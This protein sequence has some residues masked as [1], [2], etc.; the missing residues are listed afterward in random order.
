MRCCTIYNIRSVFDRTCPQPKREGT[1][2]FGIY[3][4]IAQRIYS[5]TVGT[6]SA[7]E[8]LASK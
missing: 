2:Q 7:E 3:C 4:V 6:Q 1:Y 8:L 5:A